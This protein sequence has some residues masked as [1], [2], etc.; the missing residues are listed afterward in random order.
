MSPTEPKVAKSSADPVTIL[1]VEDEAL[2]RMV[3]ADILSEAGYRVLE[4]QNADEAVAILEG[5]D[6][7]ELMFTDIRMPGQMDGLELATFVHANWPAVRLLV[8]SGHCIM[9]DSDLPNGGQFV[10][11]PYNLKELVSQIR[12]IVSPGPV[13]AAP[14]S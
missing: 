13:P 8:T 12:H 5:A 14:T 1:V 3:S 7:V 6:H 10:R 9:P 4:A 2:V 11:K